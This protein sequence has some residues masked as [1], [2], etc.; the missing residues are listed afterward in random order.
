MQNNLFIISGPSGAGEDSIIQGLIKNGVI[1]ERV[2]T[3]TS[4]NM[5]SGEVNGNPYYFLSREDFK[6]KI[7]NSE[8]FEW[9]KE[10]NNNYYGVTNDEIKRVERCGKVGIWKIGYKG[11]RTAKKLLPDIKA[12][13][14]NAPLIQIEA[15]IRARDKG[16]SDE[17]IAERM[18]YTKEWLEYK[19]LYDYEVVNSNGNLD[20]SIQAVMEILDVKKT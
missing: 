8:F 18:M 1:L 11:V 5:R 19:Y 7:D 9:A 14:I 15:R 16:V 17:Y 6:K 12:I 10:Y 13:L 4:R 3:S 20:K 2:I